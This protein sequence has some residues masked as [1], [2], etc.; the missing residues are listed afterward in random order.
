MDL[1]L[2]RVKILRNYKEYLSLIVKAAQK[3]LDNPEVYLFGSVLKGEIVAASDIDVLIVSSVP[4]KHM[5]RADIIAKI[6]L[7]VG[8]PLYHPFHIILINFEEFEKWKRIYK[9]ELKKI[10][11]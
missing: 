10:S 11:G 9:L 6:E 2:K 1:D 3:Y 8:L 5:L 7:D 4:Q